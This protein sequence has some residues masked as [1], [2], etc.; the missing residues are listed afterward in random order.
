MSKELKEA[1]RI[2]FAAAALTGL[3]SEGDIP[4]VDFAARWSFKYADAM[5]K[6]LATERSWEYE[7]EERSI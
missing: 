7:P 5:L 3:L 6:Q 1:L 2:K 4:D